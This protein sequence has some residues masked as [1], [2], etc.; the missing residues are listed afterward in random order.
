MMMIRIKIEFEFEV[1]YSPPS[2]SK[3]ESDEAPEPEQT[4]LDD[5]SQSEDFN[6]RTIRKGTNRDTYA[7]RRKFLYQCGICGKP[8]YN[9]RSHG[10]HSG[11]EEE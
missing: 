10:E 9:S 2:A 4:S 11:D 8:G 1:A 5:F 6:E 3:F 7:K